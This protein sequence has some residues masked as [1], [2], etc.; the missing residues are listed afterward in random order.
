MSQN[1]TR[2]VAGSHTGDSATPQRESHT[3]SNSFMSC[4]LPAAELT[5]RRCPEWRGCRPESGWR[6]PETRLGRK[7]RHRP[8]GE[9]MP[10]S[11]P[12]TAKKN[13]KKKTLLGGGGGGWG[14]AP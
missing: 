3:S 5:P 10:A 9:R 11:H 1:N 2:R 12:T 14:F 13:E 8:G 4:L 6:Y 7:A